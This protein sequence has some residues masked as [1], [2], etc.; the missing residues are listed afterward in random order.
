MKRCLFS[1]FYPMEFR[2]SWATDQLVSF[3]GPLKDLEYSVCYY[4]SDFYVD[5]DVKKC[6]SDTNWVSGVVIACI[7]MFFRMIQCARQGYDGGKFYRTEY[8]YN[9]FKYVTSMITSLFSYF[10][11]LPPKYS[12]LYYFFFYGWIFFATLSLCYSYFWDLKFDWAFLQPKSK[13]RILRDKL[14]YHKPQ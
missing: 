2:I 11:K 4:Y 10:Y 14:S 8:F 13:F 1:A 5:A 9:F 12:E 7:P 3:V 6:G